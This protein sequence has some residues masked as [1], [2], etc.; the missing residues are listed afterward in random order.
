MGIISPKKQNVAFKALIAFFIL[1]LSPVLLV[2][3]L[4]YLLW[5][6]ILYL[7]I[8]ITWRK[9]LVIFVYSNSPTWKEYIE[10][11]ILPHL[12]DRVVILNWSERRNW[13]NS[14]AVLAFRYFGGYRN[15]NPIGLVFRPFRSVKAYRFYEAFKE[16]K[17]G[18]TSKVETLRKALLNDVGI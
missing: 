2:A 6:A 13:K 15:F 5:G 18:H 8:W 7:A 17:H 9:Q 11:E 16:H 4:F 10:R 14:L 12:H 1:I 3:V